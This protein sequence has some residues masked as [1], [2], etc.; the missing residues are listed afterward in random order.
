M[1]ILNYS[2]SIAASKTV[3]EIQ[4]NL[5]RHGAS[6]ILIEYGNGEPSALSFKIDTPHGNLPFRLPI[7]PKRVLA[8][9]QRQKV[10]RSYCNY[11]Q[12]VKVAWRLLKDWVAVQMAYLE[13]EQVTIDQ[14]L[15][16]YLMV[17]EN[18][19]LYDRMV[20]KGFKKLTQG[21]QGGDD[22]PD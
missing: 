10:P 15:L 20:D 19:T 8:V 16:P 13:T 3:A 9:M 17:E 5:S 6:A 4:S 21:E 12:A 22:T 2:T 11:E 18:K 14:L 1:P 7:D